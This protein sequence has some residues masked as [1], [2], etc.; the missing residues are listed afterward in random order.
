M[1]AILVLGLA[2]SGCATGRPTVICPTTAS[3]SAADQ[4]S[5]A[6]ELPHDGPAAQRYI[7]DYSGLMAQVRACKESH[8]HG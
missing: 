4:K 1:R 5:L 2:L 6:E 3:Y 7:L 8:L